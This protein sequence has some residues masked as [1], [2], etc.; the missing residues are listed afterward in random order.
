MLDATDIDSAHYARAREA[1]TAEP[2]D[3]ERDRHA[4]TGRFRTGNRAWEARSS[5]GPKPLFAD[6]DSLWRSCIEYFRW[7][8]DNPLREV[9]LVAFRGR[10]THVPVPRMRPMTRTGLC[11]H[12]HV[13]HTTWATWRTRPDLAASVERAESIIRIWN[14]C[15]AAAGLLNTTMVASELGMAAKRLRE[16]E[17]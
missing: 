4:T 8:E 14:F 16:Q 5:A 2:I 9:Q 6:S 11:R 10:A 3:A 1:P 13:A 12:L 7:V 17:R 15:G